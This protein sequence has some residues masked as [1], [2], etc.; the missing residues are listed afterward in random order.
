MLDNWTH[1][2]RSR[3]AKAVQWTG[4]NDVRIFDMLIKHGMLGEIYKGAYI[5]V[6]KHGHLVHTLRHNDWVFEGEDSCLRFLCDESYKSRYQPI[7]KDDELER[8]RAF[9]RDVLNLDCEFCDAAPDFPALDK[10]ALLFMAVE[11]GLII[12]EG[13]YPYSYVVSGSLKAAP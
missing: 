13:P 8:L 11:H 7:V 12:Q 3:R 5:Y 4:F 10:H 6:R 1:E 2:R 9:A